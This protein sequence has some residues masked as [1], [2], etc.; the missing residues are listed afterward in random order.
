[1][2]ASAGFNSSVVPEMFLSSFVEGVRRGLCRMLIIDGGVQ[3]FPAG[4]DLFP[5]V[6]SS[7]SYLPDGVFRLESVEEIL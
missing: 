2:V 4:S 3:W 6:S 1:M 7:C 5:M